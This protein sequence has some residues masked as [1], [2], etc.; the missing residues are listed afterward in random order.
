MLLLDVFPIIFASWSASKTIERKLLE[1]RPRFVPLFL[2]DILFSSINPTERNEQKVND[3][4]KWFMCQ[5]SVKRRNTIG[6][7]RLKFLTTSNMTSLLLNLKFW[8]KFCIVFLLLKS[9]SWSVRIRTDGFAAK[10]LATPHN[11]S[12]FIS[13]EFKFNTLFEREQLIEHQKKL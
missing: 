1:E 13:F 11:A 2:F 10:K 4:E 5:R 3:I 7:N 8:N 12:S 6:Q 9:W